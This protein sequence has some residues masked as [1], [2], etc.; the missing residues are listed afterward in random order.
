M[1]T[2]QG[3]K[4]LLAGFCFPIVMF[5]LASVSS[6]S[7]QTMPCSSTVQKQAPP[8]AVVEISLNKARI[9]IGERPLVTFRIT[10]CG[11]FPFYIPK[12]I[13]DVEWHGGFQDILNW[14]ANA[15][16]VH[17]GRAADFGPDYHPEIV[18]EVEESWILLKPGDFYGGTV[19]LNTV[20]KS[21]GTWTIV[22]RRNPPRIPDEVRE[23]LRT[24]LK[25][26]VLL[27][28]VESKPIYLRVVK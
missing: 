9:H 20:P 24:N 11:S 13:E 16:A 6:F 14:P 8:K 17:T 23:R 18:K 27:D 21:P 1:E 4:L 3:G 15:E 10:N 28:A 2:L 5:L 19:R 22:G 26:P 12:T 7:A 25:F